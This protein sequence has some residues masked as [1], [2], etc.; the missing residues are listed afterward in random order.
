[1]EEHHHPQLL[2][3]IPEDPAAVAPTSP[4]QAQRAP[5]DK[6]SLVEMDE[7]LTLLAAAAVVL[8]E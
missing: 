7:V 6:V 1:V 5:Q 8:A 4:L 3:Q 2:L